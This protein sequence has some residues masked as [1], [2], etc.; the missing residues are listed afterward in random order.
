M[1]VSVDARPRSEQSQA[2]GDSRHA[3]A[4]VEATNKWIGQSVPRLEDPPLVRGRGRFAGDIS[5]PHQL[6]MRIVRSNHAHGKIAAI[7]SSAARALAGVV[8]VWTAAD[9]ADV[10]PIDFREGQIP[11][12][13]PYRQPVLATE[14]VRYVGEP[15]AAIF[16]DDPYVAEDAA[17]LVSLEIEELPVLLAADAEPNEFSAGRSTEVSIIRQGYGDV[18]AILHAAPKVVELEL[19]IGRHSGVPLEARGAIGRYD[20]A[21]DT[22]ELHGAAKVPHRNRELLARMLKRAPSSI[23]VH[24]SHVGGGF[25]IRGE[26][27]PEDVLVCIAAMR[28]NRPVKWIE[29]RREHL[30][31]ANHSRQQLHRLRAAVDDEGRILAIDDRYF[32]DQGAYVRTHAARVVH[33]TAGILPGPYRVPAYRAVGHFRLTNKTPAATYRAP[34]RYETTFVRERLIDAIATRLGIDPNE[35]RRRNA[36]ATDEMPYHRP[37]EALGEEIEYDSGDYVGLLDKLLDTLEWDKRKVELARRRAAGE[38][39]GAGFAMFVEK[40][41]LGPADGVRL[42]VDRSGAVELVTGGASLGQGFET[43]MAQVCAEILDIDYRRVRVT[44]GQTDRIPYGIGA[45]ASRATVMTASATHDGAVKLRAKA[46]EAAAALMQAHPETL[47]IIDGNVRRRDEPAGPSMSLGDIAEH[48]AP[49]SK[50]LGGRMPGLSAEG[51]FRVRHQVY[52]YG[53]HFAVV[54]VDPDTGDVEV[55]D[56]VIA[57]DIGRAVNPALVKGQIVGGF[58][59]GLGGALLEEFTYNERGDPLATTFAD[60]LMPTARETPEVRIMLREDYRS[61]LNPLGIKGA[62]ESGITGVGA[63]IAS[64]IDDAI[65]MPGAVTQL[66]VT[67][68]RLK[69]LLSRPHNSSSRVRATS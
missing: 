19:A 30:M 5:F 60:Y 40:S 11:A 31:A 33:M 12:L 61:P 42:E 44:H 21:R 65:G 43:V 47:E 41:G 25:G 3:G 15:V 22:L 24:E 50:T 10:P 2:S 23:H 45:H 53:L 66:P 16:A 13:E 38:A 57:Y 58:V 26:L 4:T 46:I 6:H 36:I 49:T 63:A 35:V 17:E 62:G 54:K 29:D 9:I 56:Y 59:Q 68:Q 52:P 14:K 28:L 7:D 20:I 69:Q 18:D 48:L 8:A 37:L 64:A 32:H 67:P 27:Y 55:E 39:V 34:G 1:T 51:W